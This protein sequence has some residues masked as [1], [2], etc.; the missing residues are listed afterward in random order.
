[1]ATRTEQETTGSF[2]L[3]GKTMSQTCT[4]SVSYF[5]CYPDPCGCDGSCCQG[6]NCSY[7]NC[8]QSTIG[9]GGCCTCNS[10]NYGYAWPGC[11]LCSGGSGAGLCPNCGGYLAFSTNCQQYIDTNRVSTGPA[12]YLK[13]IADFTKPLFMQYA[14][15]SN[16]II[17]G[18]HATT[19]TC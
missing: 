6:P 2:K 16:G 13:R 7:P 18:M 10:G 12:L 8:D 11:N 17:T 14:P 4:G 19:G 3:G 15:L 5:C 1:M 9:P